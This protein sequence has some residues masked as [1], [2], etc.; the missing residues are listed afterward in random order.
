MKI[1]SY[2]ARERQRREKLP[3]LDRYKVKMNFKP[4]V[5]FSLQDLGSEDNN[6]NN[7]P[8][9]NA[10]NNLSGNYNSNSIQNLH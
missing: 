9:I 5:Q 4:V 2:I 8:I 1:S 6:S 3:I 10:I 7:N